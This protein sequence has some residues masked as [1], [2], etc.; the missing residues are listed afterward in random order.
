MATGW[1]AAEWL[2]CGPL[3]HSESSRGREECLSGQ[4]LL[5]RRALG[6]HTVVTE[7]RGGWDS[8]HLGTIQGGGSKLSADIAF[9]I[10]T[11]LQGV[12][13]ARFT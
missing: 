3:P 2:R 11:C 7:S 6:V 4:Q 12:R 13:R 10:A 9:F 5:E 1:F 8:W